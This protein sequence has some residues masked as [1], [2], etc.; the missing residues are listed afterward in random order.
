MQ[1]RLISLVN[2][3]FAASVSAAPK[4]EQSAE[5]GPKTW[6]DP[7]TS[8]AFVAIPKGCFKMGA[9]TP[10][11]P[12]PDY[13]WGRTGYTKTASE[14]E[15][16]VHE[17]C[18]DGFWLGKYE[19]RVNE[20]QRVMG[21]DPS[22]NDALPITGINWEQAAEFARQLSKL[23]SGKFQFRLPS[24][25]EWEYACRAGLAQDIEPLTNGADGYAWYGFSKKMP[26]EGG[27]LRP[28]AFGL[29]DM[30]GNVWEWM[31]DSYAPNG[32]ARH[33]LYNP[34]VNT[35]SGQK[36]L[37]GGSFRTERVQVR[38]AMRSHHDQQSAQDTIGL[39]LVRER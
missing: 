31:A 37:R 4:M 8:M 28:N 39:R 9:E 25:A 1:R 3:T 19:V 22:P 20:W 2:I 38:C 36:V 18:L 15:K 13:F 26:Q 5:K 17:V 24:E 27:Q 14:D 34:R 16:P 32:Y 12:Q 29:H 23:S 30:L 6:Q 10:Q 35:A 7:V 11:V 21:G 33:G